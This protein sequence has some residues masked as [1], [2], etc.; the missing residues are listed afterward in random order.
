M[1]GK[2]RPRESPVMAGFSPIR[3]MIRSLSIKCSG[4]T[5]SHAAGIRIE[6]TE[7]KLVNAKPLSLLRY[8]RRKID[9]NVHLDSDLIVLPRGLKFLYQP[10][11][12]FCTSILRSGL[13]II[14]KSCYVKG[15]FE[16][17]TPIKRTWRKPLSRKGFTSP[18]RPERKLFCW[19]DLQD[20]W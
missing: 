10:N 6:N 5:G 13:R 8:F 4:Y 14:Q 12:S 18:L 2:P 15:L 11:T 20:R 19:A 16:M 9:R 7:L 17:P 1:P 3:V